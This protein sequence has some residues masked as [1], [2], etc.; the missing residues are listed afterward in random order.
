MDKLIIYI[1]DNQSLTKAGMMVI[2]RDYFKEHADITDCANKNFLFELLKNKFWFGYSEH[3]DWKIVLTKTAELSAWIGD[4][5]P[6]VF[7]FL[8]GFVLVLSSLSKEITIKSFYFKRFERLYPTYILIHILINFF[9]I[10][11]KYQPNGSIIST[12]NIFSLL[13]LRFTNNMFFYLNPFQ[14][15]S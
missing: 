14:N 12:Q 15:I 11:I 8:S 6:G 5:G 3:L 9:L 7:I 10:F 2:L 1:A 4:M 13:G